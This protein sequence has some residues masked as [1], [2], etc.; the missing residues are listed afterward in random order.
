MLAFVGGDA[1]HTLDFVEPVDVFCVTGIC[2]FLE[3]GQ[4]LEVQVAKLD[5]AASCVSVKKSDLPSWIQE[6]MKLLLTA[7]RQ[8]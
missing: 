4:K 8:A 1:E 3:F 2:V 7:L 6:N 5:D